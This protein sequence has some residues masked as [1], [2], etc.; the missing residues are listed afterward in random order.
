M[1]NQK[2][3]LENLLNCLK[4]SQFDLAGVRAVTAAISLSLDDLYLPDEPV[5]LRARVSGPAAIETLK[6]EITPVTGDRP[7]LSF[8]FVE[9]QD[10]E[11]RLTI[12]ALPP[13]LYRVTARTEA[14]TDPVPTPVHDLFEVV[15]SA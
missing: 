5:S 7:A 2:Q 6:A 15:P 11:W 10:Q 12:D 1:Q 9:E 8:D 4:L 3:V 14:E 13:G